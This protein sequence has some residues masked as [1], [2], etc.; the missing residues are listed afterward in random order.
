MAHLAKQTLALVLAG[1]RG[2][3]LGPLT[4]WRA[5]PAVPFGGK[6]RIIDFALSNC[7]N[8]GI[9]RIGIATQYKAQSLIRHVQRGW[10]FL[11]GRFNEFVELLP[12]Q[13]RIG[14]EWYRGT[15]D[16]VLQNLDIIRRHDPRFVLI[17]AG[18][19]VYKMDYARMIDEHVARRADMTVGCVEAPIAD[20]TQ[21]GV[22][23]VDREYRVIGFD[24][25][26]KQPKCIPGRPD[27]ALGSMGIYVFSA[28][29]LYEQLLRDADDGRSAHD[30]G[31]NII[32]HL[33]ECGYRVYAHRFADSCMQSHDGESYWRDAGT[34]DAYWE[35]NM[36]LTRVNPALDLY[37]QSWPIWTYQEQLP[38]AKFVFDDDGRRGA[39]VDSMVSGGCLI[40]GST[41]RRSLLF[42]SVYVHSYCEIEDA[43]ILPNVEI[44][45][46]VVLKRV[47]VDKGAKIPPGTQIGVDPEADR[48]RFHVSEKGI[49]LVTPEM[50]GQRI[51]QIR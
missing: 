47:V 32:P 49:T 34:V 45:R 35:A 30:F 26:P 16:A 39:A 13:Q 14:D 19:H 18:D 37:D 11:D 4:D 22:M 12:A 31:H 3:R 9:R 17:L 23:A 1:G 44:G 38:P 5:K 27:V 51:H 10:S 24:E 33:V 50:L 8:S 41:I 48:Q 46:N 43:V 2:T 6:F 40:S 36:E 25:K 15:A 21:L 28:D 42:S 20:A 7:V 29:F